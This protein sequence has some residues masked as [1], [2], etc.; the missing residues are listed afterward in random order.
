MQP[1][2]YIPVYDGISLHLALFLEQHIFL[3]R[4]DA[5]SSAYTGMMGFPLFF[6]TISFA[7][8][9]PIASPTCSATAWPTLAHPQP[10]N[11]AWKLPRSL[12]LVLSPAFKLFRLLLSPLC[13]QLVECLLQNSVAENGHAMLG[14]ACT[15]CEYF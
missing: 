7:D 9:S 10:G 11:T 13:L 5:T 12:Q 1:H 8:P 14:C 6:I 2:R 4:A 3:N 15:R